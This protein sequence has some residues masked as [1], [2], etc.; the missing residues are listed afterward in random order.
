MVR[1]RFVHRSN[2]CFRCLGRGAT[3]LVQR[4]QFVP[5]GKPRVYMSPDL[6]WVDA[7]SFAAGVSPHRRRHGPFWPSSRARKTGLLLL[8]WFLKRWPVFSCL[9]PGSGGIGGWWRSEQQNQSCQQQRPGEDW[10]ECDKNAAI[11]AL[12]VLLA[13]AW[14]G[15]R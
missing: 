3:M 1:E 11:R 7:R 5:L 2:C 9:L 13:D 12:A 6:F 4:F 10:Q 14:R 15:C 8:R